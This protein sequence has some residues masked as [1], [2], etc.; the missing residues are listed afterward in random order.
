MKKEQL[1]LIQ[2]E[3]HNIIHK[4]LSPELFKN[5]GYSDLSFHAVFSERTERFKGTD[6]YYDE[7]KKFVHWTSIQNLMSIINNREIRLYN[8]QNSADPEEFNFA[9]N[10][11]KIQ[12]DRSNY[13]KNY[14]YTFSFCKALE[15]NNPFLWKTYG[16]DYKGVAIEFEIDNSIDEW[17]NFMLSSVYYNFP[18]ML[19]ELIS[20]LNSFKEKY[21]GTITEIDLG[22]LIAFHKHS[23]YGNEKEVRLSTYFPFS[24]SE[25]Y[26]KYCQTEFQFNNDRPRITNYF[27]LKL[28]VNNDSPYLQSYNPEYD[29][30]QIIEDQYF[31]K[32]P[33]IKIKNIHFGKNCGLTNRTLSPFVQKIQDIF[34]YKF[35]YNF[36]LPINLFE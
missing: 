19:I 5:Y 24:D 22:K 8:L 17:E 3:F 33:K 27:P 21:P 28:W 6:Y 16:N 1:D 10:Q 11:L 25:A 34:P 26:R 36:E 35:G 32:N 9:A 2:K 20:N 13:S 29:N 30:K 12:Q 31:A 18:D 23:K 14:L 15:L 7:D 4:H